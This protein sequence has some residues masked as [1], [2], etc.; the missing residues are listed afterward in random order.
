MGLFKKLFGSKKKSNN[1]H[2][3]DADLKKEAA[4]TN[5]S[6]NHEEE[7]QVSA[8]KPPTV[9]VELQNDI[10]KQLVNDEKKI[11]LV[12]VRT[13]MTS[14]EGADA[15]NAFLAAGILDNKLRKEILTQYTWHYLD[16]L[17]A[18]LQC[19]MQLVLTE[20]LEQT[21]PFTDSRHIF[22]QIMGVEYQEFG[23]YEFDNHMDEEE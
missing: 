6:E 11:M 3:S 15:Q 9:N 10:R 16:D 7:A 19:T 14:H 4:I 13:N 5:E 23:D 1:M 20:V 17:D 8:P 21:K 2:S 12:Q 18:N 22:E